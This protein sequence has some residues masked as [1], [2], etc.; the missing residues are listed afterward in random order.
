M[1]SKTIRKDTMKF[2]ISDFGFRILTRIF[3]ISGYNLLKIK[4]SYF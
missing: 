3:M 4:Y 2:R 1:N